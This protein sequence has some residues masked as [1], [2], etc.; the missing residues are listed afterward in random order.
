MMRIFTAP[1]PPERLRAEVGGVAS[2]RAG[3]IERCPGR[4]RSGAF[5]LIELIIVISMLGLFILLAQVNLFGVLR[6]STFRSQVQD[7][8]ST[9]QMAASKA[10]ESD[11]RYEV[12]IDLTEQGYLLREITSSDLSEVLDEE[13]VAQGWFGNN[14]RV[15]YV[16]FDDGDYTNEDRAKFR[17]GYA[18]W[19]YGGKVVFL[20]ESEQSYAVVV[21]RLPPIIQLVEGDPALMAPKAKDEVPFL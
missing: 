10:A 3:S 6:R 18:G 9:M 21:N 13:I 1:T 12:I 4:V 8:V 19:Q 15:A 7:F 20:D 17:A 5:T 16:E 14:C 2:S 11:R